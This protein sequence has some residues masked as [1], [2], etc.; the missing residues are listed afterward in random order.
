MRNRELD[1]TN[2]LLASLLSSKDLRLVHN[3]ELRAAQRELR[4]A[5]KGG[6]DESRRIVRAVK[7]IS[8]V[9]CDVLTVKKKG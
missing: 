7:L 4:R 3:L 6:K 2:R 1:E 8:K 5:S 9:L